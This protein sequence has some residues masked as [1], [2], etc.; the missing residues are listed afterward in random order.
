[1]VFS[2]ITFLFYFLP[3]MLLCY[4]LVP[5][6]IKNIILLIGSFI[7]YFWGE[8]KNVSIMIS[9]IAL[10]YIGGLLIHKLKE[11]NSKYL[12]LA[13]WLIILSVLSLLFILNI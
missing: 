5:K 12:K 8:P 11:K 9:V 1:M 13:L 10:S 2:S 7:F 3:I 4:Y 6:K